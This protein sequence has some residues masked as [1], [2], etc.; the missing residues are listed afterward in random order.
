MLKTTHCFKEIL[1]KSCF[2][3]PQGPPDVRTTTSLQGN[4][5]IEIL[6]QTSRLV[7]ARTSG[8]EKSGLGGSV[9]W[10]V[11]EEWRELSQLL[12]DMTLQPD[13]AHEMFNRMGEYLIAKE[14]ILLQMNVD[15]IYFGDDLG[16]KTGRP[17]HQICSGD[18][19]IPGIRN[20]A[21]LLMRT[22]ATRTC[23]PMVIL[24]C[25]SE[26]WWRRELIS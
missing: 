7:F 21:T 20:S 17:C 26:T 8:G 3:P 12:C 4:W 22:I 1:I 5:C 6:L 23:T 15:C 14:K 2:Y 11:A 9:F 25:C 18:F 13:F 24:I 19:C 16:N 10:S